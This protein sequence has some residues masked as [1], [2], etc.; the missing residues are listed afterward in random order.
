[1]TSVD[2]GTEWVVVG[3]GSTTDLEQRQYVQCLVSIG[4]TDLWFR[5]ESGAHRRACRITP[6][7]TPIVISQM[8]TAHAA[9]LATRK[10]GKR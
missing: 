5:F 7:P 4:A 6:Q 2:T 8:R 1:M 9:R 3:E 10:S